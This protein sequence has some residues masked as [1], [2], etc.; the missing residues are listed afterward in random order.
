M[1]DENDNSGVFI[2]IREEP[3]EPWMPVN[4]GLEVQID[5]NDDEFHRTGVLYSFTKAMASPG[6]P[7]PIWNTMYITLDGLRTVVVVNSAK[8]T[9]F[10]QTAYFTPPPRKHDWEPAVGA[11]P[12]AG[13][14]G[15]QNH[16]DRDVVEFKEVAPRELK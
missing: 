10:T 4:K 8:V 6:R 7:G 11:R 9:D 14:I 16:S 13:W 3:T 1:R 15:L 2:R 5:N 12:N